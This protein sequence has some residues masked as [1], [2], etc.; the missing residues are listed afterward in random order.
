MRMAWS[1]RNRPHGLKATRKVFKSVEVVVG[2]ET[3][4]VQ[5][6]SNESV[7]VEVDPSQSK[8]EFNEMKTS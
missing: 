3:E 2:S 1:E 8:F 5:L 7:W 4:S 6:G